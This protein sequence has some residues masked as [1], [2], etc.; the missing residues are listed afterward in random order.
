[1]IANRGA[2]TQ[3]RAAEQQLRSADWRPVYHGEDTVMRFE[4]F[5]ERPMTK[6]DRFGVFAVLVTLFLL[7]QPVI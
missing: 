2:E 3:Q 4:R 7:M 1:M 6:D 5:A